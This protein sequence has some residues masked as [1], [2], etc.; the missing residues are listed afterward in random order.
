VKKY[1]LCRICHNPMMVGQTDTHYVCVK[2][3]IGNLE[4]GLELS[5]GSADAKWDTRQAAAVDQAIRNAA[6]KKTFITAD[7]IWAELPA[8]FPVGKGLA[9][10]LLAASRAGVIENTGTTTTA[11]R[12]GAHDHAQRLTIWRSLIEGRNPAMTL[13]RGARR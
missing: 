6:A 10:R 12:G 8:T 9:A 11:R 3:P 2:D 7:D 4:R 1:P 5:Q 13:D